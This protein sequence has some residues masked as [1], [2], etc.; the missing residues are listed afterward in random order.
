[1][2]A[3]CEMCKLD[4][5]HPAEH[6]VVSKDRPDGYWV[7]HKHVGK[8]RCAKCDHIWRPRLHAFKIPE[9]CPSC[10]ETDDLFWADDGGWERAARERL[11]VRDADPYDL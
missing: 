3:T 2:E 7:C 8:V 4:V 11:R 5:P 6:Y 1:M 9:R 10:S